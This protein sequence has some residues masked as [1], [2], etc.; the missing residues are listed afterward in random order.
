MARPHTI[1]LREVKKNVSP[2][3][4]HRVIDASFKEVGPN[5]RT[6]WGRF[7]LAALAVACAAAIG[8]LIPPLWRIAQLIAEQFAP[9]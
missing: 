5:R 3:P 7:K 8:F 4:A 6:F 1:R 9:L 2:A